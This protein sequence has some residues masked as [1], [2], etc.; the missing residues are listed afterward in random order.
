MKK[1]FVPAELELVL[2]NTDVIKTSPPT[3]GDLDDLSL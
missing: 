3:E 2:F 1:E